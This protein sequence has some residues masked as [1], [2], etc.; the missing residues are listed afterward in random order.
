MDFVD[1]FLCFFKV[2]SH[3]CHLKLRGPPHLSL[4]SCCFTHSTNVLGTARKITSV[5]LSH[6]PCLVYHAAAWMLG[7]GGEMQLWPPGESRKIIDVDSTG[8]KST[9]SDFETI[10]S[11]WTGP[12]CLLS[13]LLPSPL[14][15]HC[16]PSS[17]LSPF[18][19]EGLIESHQWV[20]LRN[21]PCCYAGTFLPNS[22]LLSLL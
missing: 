4:P 12:L 2:T 17:S 5:Q 18:F 15:Q 3:C 6:S 22:L 13:P 9:L 1:S 21:S 19:E 11:L 8:L 7:W 20:D 14:F 16:L 10:L